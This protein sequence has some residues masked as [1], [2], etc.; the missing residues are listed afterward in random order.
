LKKA[1][2]NISDDEPDLT[3]P[4]GFWDSADRVSPGRR[5]ISDGILLGHR[6]RLV[7]LLSVTWPQI[8]PDL[9]A[10]HTPE[11][12][13]KAFSMVRGH[14]GEYLISPFLEQSSAPA[15]ETKELRRLRKDIEE[16]ATKASQAREKRDASERTFHQFES[17]MKMAGLLKTEKEEKN[18]TAQPEAI[19]P[20][21]NQQQAT[22]TMEY[23]KRL[24][25]LAS[26]NGASDESR[27]KERDLRN[28]LAAKEAAFAQT[29]LA[30][31]IA[32]EKYAR[33][34]CTQDHAR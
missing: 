3:G 33:N 31:F 5:T 15:C 6:D 18:K 2:D 24:A 22:L 13:R 14:Q 25:Q 8:G 17:A 1:V 27:D 12:V 28:E 9:L 30:G 7:W 11:K 34:L 20:L 21:S 4:A 26:A 10:A 16:A 32:K 19:T 29:E 23:N